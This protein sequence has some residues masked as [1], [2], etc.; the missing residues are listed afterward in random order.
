MLCQGLDGSG[1]KC[2]E[3]GLCAPL[4]LKLLEDLALRVVAQSAH[5]DEAAQIKLLR[6]EHRHLGRF[7]DLKRGNEVGTFEAEIISR[8]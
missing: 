5:F 8:R 4:S 6:A 3:E 7:G 2:G 1:G